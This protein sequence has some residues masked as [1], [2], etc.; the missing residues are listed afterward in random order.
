MQQPDRDVVWT[1]PYAGVTY[2]TAASLDCWVAP[3]LPSAELY[4]EGQ[5]IA[6]TMFDAPKRVK[7][8]TLHFDGI[9][10]GKFTGDMCIS[11]LLLFGTK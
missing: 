11:E 4:K 6:V 5:H 7:S 1:V 2:S 9:R 3:L 8:L 10:P